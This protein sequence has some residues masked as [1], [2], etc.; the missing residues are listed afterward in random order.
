MGE[1]DETLR[2]R[3]ANQT[4]AH[5][6]RRRCVSRARHLGNRVGGGEGA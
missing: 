4:I 5:L 6:Q 1:L 2:D 3:V